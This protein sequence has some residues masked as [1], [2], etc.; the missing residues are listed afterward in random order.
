MGVSI[1]FH[2]IK[3][4]RKERPKKWDA[5]GLLPSD[6]RGD[7]LCGHKEE[8]AVIDAPLQMDLEAFVILD[9]GLSEAVDLVQRCMLEARWNL[10]CLTKSTSSSSSLSY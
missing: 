1:P 9:F 3:I 2:F 10:V 6:L 5:S 7:F 8:S 4:G